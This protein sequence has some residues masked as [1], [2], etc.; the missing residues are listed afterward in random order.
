[1]SQMPWAKTLN[2]NQRAALSRLAHGRILYGGVGSGKSRVALA[3]FAQEEHEI[4]NVYVI[5][6]AKKRDSKDWEGEAARIGLGKEKGAT[7]FSIL[8]VDSW[9]NIEKYVDVRDAFFIFDEQR[10]VGKGVWVKAFLKIAKN[11]RW[12]L[13]SATPGDT[14]MDYIPV[15]LANGFYKSRSEFIREH[16]I[17]NSWTK[18][19]KVDRYVGVGKL[20]RFRNNLL[21]ELKYDKQTVR[22]SEIIKVDY[23]REMMD[24][25][26]KERWNVLQNL[27]I[28]NVTELFICMRRVVN[29]DPSRL[30]AV[31]ELM[32][33]HDKLIVFY[34][35]NFER[36]KLLELARGTQVSEWS[37][38]RH[39]ELPRGS[40]WVYL[41]Q[42]VAGSE[43]WNCTE[44][45]AVCF[46]S[47]TYSYKNW[48]QAHGRIDRLN[49]KF[50]DLYYYI[51]MSEAPI[52]RAVWRALKGK[53][54]FQIPKSWQIL[55][56]G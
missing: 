23:D 43:G 4:E 28:K 44:T 47:L 27:P 5:T 37:G 3:F 35:F 49:T 33:K 22:H 34:N 38:H 1:L 26:V 30:E 46:Y 51:L 16:V 14:W 10:L 12:I 7:Y 40:K 15:F 48:E 20:V 56:N 29:E 32:K 31:R 53:K 6:T 24:I 54:S 13:L 21:V 39:Q 9:N 41:V 19:P 11:N 52:D 36:S 55:A 8:T 45:N 2:Q 50:V 42:Y 17:Y 25:V 18:F